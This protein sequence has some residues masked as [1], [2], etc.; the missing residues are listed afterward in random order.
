MT[1]SNIGYF[2]SIYRTLLGRGESRE[3]SLDF[4]RRTIQD[5]FDLA[6]ECFEKEDRFF[7]DTGIMVINAIRECKVG[8]ENHAKTYS[9]DRMHVA[10]IDVLL[11]SIDARLKDLMLGIGMNGVL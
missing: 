2:T 6:Q 7:K 9:G 10:K 4:F 8:I 3:R 1:L 11:L 5:G